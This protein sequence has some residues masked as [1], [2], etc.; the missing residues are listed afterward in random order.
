M[1]L[2]LWDF[3]LPPEPAPSQSCSSFI[4]ARWGPSSQA[5]SGGRC[6][7]HPR[8]SVTSPVGHHAILLS[9][10]DPSAAPP[11]H[12]CSPGLR[13][14][15]LG[16]WLVSSLWSGPCTLLSA[17]QRSECPFLAQKLQVGGL[18]KAPGFHCSCRE[19][20]SQFNYGSPKSQSGSFL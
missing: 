20:S 9:I 1:A 3:H 4:S 6:G 15:P 12:C 16:F 18:S 13:H 2:I 10:P 5:A 17:W 14:H 7:L 11:P 19:V 8:L